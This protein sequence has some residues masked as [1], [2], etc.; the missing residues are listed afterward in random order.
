MGKVGTMLF[1][2]ISLVLS[3]FAILASCDTLQDSKI[4][5]FAIRIICTKQEKKAGKMKFLGKVT[6]LT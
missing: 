5:L 4:M 6:L 2:V 3:A 1:T